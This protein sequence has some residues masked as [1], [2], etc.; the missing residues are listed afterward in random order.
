MSP[1]D[2]TEN[3][4]D[5]VPAPIPSLQVGESQFG[6]GS[7]IYTKGRGKVLAYS[8]K[9]TRK[10]VDSDSTADK[11]RKRLEDVKL[12]NEK[13]SWE[14]RKFYKA[15]IVL[16]NIILYQLDGNL[17]YDQK[18]GILLKAGDAL[19][20]KDLAQLLGEYDEENQ[21]NSDAQNLN[22]AEYQNHIGLYQNMPVGLNQSKAIWM[23]I[24]REMKL[25]KQ[26]LGMVPS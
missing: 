2:Q 18:R 12:R 11:N 4:P 5:T 17:T 10:N 7:K 26:V 3:M 9:R 6:L 21:S 25:Q 22:E 1:K 13:S 19:A 8:K 14:M 20:E 24:D 16:N 15:F 23:E